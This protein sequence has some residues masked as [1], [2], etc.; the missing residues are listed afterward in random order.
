M[1]ENAV[2]VR[3]EGKSEEGDAECAKGN[4]GHI[5]RARRSVSLCDLKLVYDRRYP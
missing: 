1:M 5:A 3:A 4:A 2:H